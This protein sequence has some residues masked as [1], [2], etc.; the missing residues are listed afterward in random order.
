[1]KS[2]ALLPFPFEVSFDDYHDAQP[3]ADFLNE[4]LPDFNGW[5]HPVETGFDDEKGQYVF[6]FRAHWQ[7]A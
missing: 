5:V 2:V 3:H 4:V 6:E 1:M 7:N